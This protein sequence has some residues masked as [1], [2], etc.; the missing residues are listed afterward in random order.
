MEVTPVQYWSLDLHN[1]P[2]SNEPEIFKNIIARCIK[3]AIKPGF[4][5]MFS[6]KERDFLLDLASKLGLEVKD[7]D[8]VVLASDTHTKQEYNE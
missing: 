8:H 7:A 6:G 5:N 2:E 4:Q 3:E 1:T